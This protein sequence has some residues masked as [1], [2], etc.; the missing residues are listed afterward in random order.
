M[1]KRSA[2]YWKEKLISE[3]WS[4]DYA[5]HVAEH[6]ANGTELPGFITGATWLPK[7]TDEATI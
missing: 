7:T 1:E 3:G 4:E 5:K 6:L 2:T